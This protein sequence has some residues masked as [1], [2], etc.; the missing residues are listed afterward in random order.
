MKCVSL[1][2]METGAS[3]E[4][5]VAVRLHVVTDRYT[6]DAYVTIPRQPMEESHA[7]V[8]VTREQTAA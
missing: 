6:E 5:G 7:P 1:Q 4:T 8:K 2:L 3:G